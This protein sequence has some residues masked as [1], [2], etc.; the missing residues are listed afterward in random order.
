MRWPLSSSCMCFMFSR[1]LHCSNGPSGFAFSSGMPFPPPKRPPVKRRFKAATCPLAARRGSSASMEKGPLRGRCS[2]QWYQ[3]SVEVSWMYSW[4]SPG[5]L[6][7][8]LGFG[9]N[10]GLPQGSIFLPTSSFPLNKSLKR[11]HSGVKASGVW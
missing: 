4:R 9:Y 3:R 6:L 11:R 7:G 5:T 1:T 8:N 10:P 2:Q